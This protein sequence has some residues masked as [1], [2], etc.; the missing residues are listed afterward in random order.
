[1][2]GGSPLVGHQ[3]VDDLT[4]ERPCVGLDQHEQAWSEH[5]TSGVKEFVVIS[6]RLCG[7]CQADTD[8]QP[9]RSRTTYR[10]APP[11]GTRRFRSSSQFWTS[12]TWIVGSCPAGLDHDEATILRD[13]APNARSQIVSNPSA[14]IPGA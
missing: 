1:M 10:A 9:E 13:I 7:T 14:R 8:S 12:T 5:G 6:S 4:S 2:E 3:V 11:D